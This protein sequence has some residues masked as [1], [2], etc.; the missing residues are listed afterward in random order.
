MDSRPHFSISGLDR[1][2][3]SPHGEA[4]ALGSALVGEPARSHSASHLCRISRPAATVELAA[5]HC[6]CPLCRRLWLRRSCCRRVLASGG[7]SAARLYGNFV[8]APAF[9][10]RLSPGTVAVPVSPKPAHYRT[11]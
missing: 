11:V 6:A 3:I 1:F 9:V 2:R 7:W 4:P 5:A 8:R 10:G